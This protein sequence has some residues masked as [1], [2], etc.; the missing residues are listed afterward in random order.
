MWPL[1]ANASFKVGDWVSIK[2]TGYKRVRVA[3]YRGALGPRG[4]R[5][6]RILLRKR[7]LD[8][9]EVREDQLEHVAEES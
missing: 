1:D 2:N 6:Y 5:I 9:V 3:E 8:Y 7:P 4:A